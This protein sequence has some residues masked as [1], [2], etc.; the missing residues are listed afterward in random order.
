MEIY[1]KEDKGYFEV[2]LTNEEQLK[3]DRTEL[4]R[5]LLS[6]KADKRYKV[7]YLLSGTGDLFANVEGLILTNLGCAKRAPQF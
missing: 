2:W 6:V 3:V 7:M 1:D 5:Q 4:T